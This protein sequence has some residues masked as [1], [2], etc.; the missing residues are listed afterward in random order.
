VLE[1]LM[2]FMEYM[3]ITSVGIILFPLSIWEGSK[4]MA[5]KL[6][7]AI[8]GF[9]IKLLFCNICIFLMLYGFISLAR[10]YSENP[11]TGRP[12]EIVVVIFIS[13]LFFFLCKSAPAL[14]QSLLTGTP[15]L[16]ASG[17]IAA[18]GGAIAGAGAALGLAGKAGGAAAGAYAKSAFAGMGAFGQASGAAQ[19]VKELGGTAGQQAGAF[20]SS[21]GGSAK[22]AFKSSGGDLARSL[23]GGGSH[24][25]AASGGSGSGI[26]RHSQRQQFLEKKNQ[27]GTKKTFGEYLAGRR[28]A[29]TNAGIDY[30]AA[31]EAQ[32]NRLMDRLANPEHAPQDERTS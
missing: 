20:L 15:S 32:R 2:A 26:N 4:F 21:I 14:A 1:Y 16:N 31:Q 19:A 18:A 7:G 22:E 24:G 8:M 30:M 6:I 25:A 13:L 27:D 3:F 17:A 28:E 5:E 23:I 11:F 12:D 9:F 29:G 10:G